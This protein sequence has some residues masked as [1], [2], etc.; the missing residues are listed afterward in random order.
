MFLSDYS[1]APR[2]CILLA[3]LVELL[4]VASIDHFWSKKVTI[5]YNST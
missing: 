4:E 5:S 1:E 3:F 2:L